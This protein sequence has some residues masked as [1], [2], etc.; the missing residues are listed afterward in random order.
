[1]VLVRQQRSRVNHQH[2]LSVLPLLACLLLVQ[3]V[4]LYSVHHNSSFMPEIKLNYSIHIPD[5]ICIWLSWHSAI[6]THCTLHYSTVVT[7]Q[8][9]HYNRVFRI[10]F[11]HCE[12]RCILCVSV[13]CFFER[14]RE[15]SENGW[16]D[17]SDRVN[18]HDGIIYETL[19]NSNM[20]HF[21]FALWLH[22]LCARERV[23]VSVHIKFP[24]LQIESLSDKMENE[25]QSQCCSR[26]WIHLVLLPAPFHT[27]F[28][29][30]KKGLPSLLHLL[31]TRCHFSGNLQLISFQFA[32]FIGVCVCVRAFLWRAFIYLTLSTDKQL[33]FFSRTVFIG[34]MVWIRFSNFQY[35]PCCLQLPD[36]NHAIIINRVCVFV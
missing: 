36:T 3:C 7:E 1:M 6:N 26:A 8:S 30:P 10:I 11:I 35:T 9:S 25:S 31:D 14:H 21:K 2:E 15:N 33:A 22:Q 5:T 16:E 29:S 34:G 20:Y 24:F 32:F 13:H 4:T 27:Q 19:N 18:E 12:K 28:V 17:K 23:C